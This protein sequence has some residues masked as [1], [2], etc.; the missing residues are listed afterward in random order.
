MSP[1]PSHG[2][3][4]FMTSLS[5]WLASTAGLVA[6]AQA[7]DARPVPGAGAATPAP[8]PVAA[9]ASAPRIVASF[10]I[11]ADL[12]AQVAPPDAQ[13][14]ALVGP[15]TDAHVFEPRPADGR[16]LLEAELVVVNGLGFEGWL[17]R[18][19]R[20]SGYRGP[21][22]VASAGIEPRGAEASADPGHDHDHDHGHAHA[23]RELDPHAWQDLRLARRYVDTLVLAM[24]ERWPERAAELRA[25]RDAYVARLEALDRQVRQWLEAVPREARRVIT[26]HQAF[27]YFGAAY[28]V[29]FLA[30]QGWN[31]VHEPSAAAVARLVRQIR[32]QRVRALFVENIRDARLIQRIADETGARVGGTLYSDALSRPG[33]PADTYLKMIEHN[34]RSLATALAG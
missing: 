3:R 32:E 20:A 18:L 28:G 2:R 4:A 14:S 26:S 12:V 5:A 33:G 15:D 30:P 25:R 6:P 27:G 16:R 31:P 21:I 11:L 19:V 17:D 1:T 10:S 8:S 24:L 13:V 9:A 29:E 34:A 23:D 22:A 7:A